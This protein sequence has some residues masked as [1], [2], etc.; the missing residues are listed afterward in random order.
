MRDPAGTIVR[1]GVGAA[2]VVLLSCGGGRGGGGVEPSSVWTIVPASA[3]HRAYLAAVDAGLPVPELLPLRTTRDDLAAVRGV[4]PSI[5]PPPP[6]VGD[7][8]CAF[9]A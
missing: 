1:F 4:E 8:L 6:G 9:P 5:P 3:E 2:A 7:G